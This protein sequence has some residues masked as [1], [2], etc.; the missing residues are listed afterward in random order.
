MTQAGFKR[1]L[2]AAKYNLITQNCSVQ[3]TDQNNITR[4]FTVLFFFIKSTVKVF[5]NLQH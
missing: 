1:L 4:Q 2:L 5:Y 3:E